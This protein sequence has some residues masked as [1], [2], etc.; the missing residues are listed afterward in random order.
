MNAEEFIP[1]WYEKTM[2]ELIEIFNLSSFE[3]SGIPEENSKNC[4]LLSKERVLAATENISKLLE[5]NTIISGGPCIDDCHY[6]ISLE[7]IYEIA[8][9]IKVGKE[10][11]K[12]VI[13]HV[14]VQEEI[15]R[16]KQSK[17]SI[18]LWK[19]TGN[20]IENII[21][22]LKKKMDYRDVFCCRSDKPEI[23]AIITKFA[24]EVQ[25][26]I[27][28][29]DARTLYRHLAGTG[30]K[31]MQD[32]FNYSIHARFLPLY[33]PSFAEEVLKTRNVRIIAYEDIQQLMA[34]KKANAL[35]TLMNSFNKGPAQIVTLP[36][37]GT[38]GKIRMH[39]FDKTKRPFINSSP[40]LLEQTAKEMSEAVF[41]FNCK[42]WPIELAGKKIQTRNE[43]AEF[44]NS[45]RRLE[46]NA[47]C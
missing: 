16:E 1:K 38:D 32:S 22:C 9:L 20:R 31:P 47:D 34:A 14:G 30:K 33:L 44:F 15:L 26:R 4:V 7:S 25:K 12:K 19:N 46:N 3:N 17:K 41:N 29:D 39:K 5:G 8:S 10:F 28:R 42:T 27:N 35:A 6:D 11:G 23:D 13:I 37:P 2:P 40:E 18:E 24:N 45:L 21:E 43:L 36:Y